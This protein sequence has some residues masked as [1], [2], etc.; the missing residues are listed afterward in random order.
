ME[1]SA[2]KRFL[3]IFAV[4]L[5]RNNPHTTIANYYQSPNIPQSTI[6]SC[7]HKIFHDCLMSSIEGFQDLDI[8]KL[9]ESSVEIERNQKKGVYPI[10]LNNS[11]EIYNN[12]CLE[13]R[14]SYTKNTSFFCH[15]W[16]NHQHRNYWSIDKTVKSPC[17]KNIVPYK[18]FLDNNSD[19]ND[20]LIKIREVPD[21]IA[22]NFIRM[23]KP[24]KIIDE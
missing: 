8:L 6:L 24:H 12:E 10:P 3:Y 13:A 16:C 5:K 14:R 1:R 9:I 15:K 2:N 18:T 20:L 22:K 23:Y 11:N 21:I 4:P 7:R 19:S 17:F